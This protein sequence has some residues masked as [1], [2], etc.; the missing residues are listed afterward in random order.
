MQQVTWV[1]MQIYPSKIYEIRYWSFFLSVTLHVSYMCFVKQAP[2]CLIIQQW[3]ANN[4]TNGHS[5]LLRN[6]LV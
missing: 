3:D 6:A 5:Q 4:R 2:D 1:V